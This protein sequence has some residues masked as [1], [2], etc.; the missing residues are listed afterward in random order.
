MLVDKHEVMKVLPLVTITLIVCA[1]ILPTVI[2]G[3]EPVIHIAAGNSHSLFIKNDG[4]LWSMG[5]NNCG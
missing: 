1:E 5:N 3:A 4:S 2:V